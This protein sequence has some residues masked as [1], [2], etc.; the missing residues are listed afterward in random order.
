MEYK[1]YTYFST[2]NAYCIVCYSR[3]P[4]VLSILGGLA[5]RGAALELAAERHSVGTVAG[6]AVV[7]TSGAAYSVPRGVLAA[8]EHVDV[9]VVQW[10]AA[11]G[12]K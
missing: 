7:N 1:Y 5:F 4:L 8:L 3:T 11:W 12:A 6:A 10:A 9:A 2:Q